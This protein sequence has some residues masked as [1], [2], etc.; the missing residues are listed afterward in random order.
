MKDKRKRKGHIENLGI[1]W[2]FIYEVFMMGEELEP[3]R[4]SKAIGFLK[5]L[6]P[7]KS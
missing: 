3:V 6:P 5:K 4:M 7:I 2:S 1:Q